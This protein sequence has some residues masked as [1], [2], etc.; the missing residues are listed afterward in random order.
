MVIKN[1]P[2]KPTSRIESAGNCFEPAYDFKQIYTRTHAF[3]RFDILKAGI[4]LLCF[5][6]P[7]DLAMPSIITLADL[8][9]PCK[10]PQSF[11]VVSLAKGYCARD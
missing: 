1:Y 3:C 9:D 7:S 5:Q 8:R 4:Q 2:S 6:T 10:I 11:Q